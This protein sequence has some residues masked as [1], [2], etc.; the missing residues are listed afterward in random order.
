MDRRNFLARGFGLTGAF[1]LGCRDRGQEGT[2]VEI[3]G[4]EAEGAPPME[5]TLGEGRAGRRFTDL[6]AIRPGDAWLP[7]ARC[8]VRSRAPASLAGRGPWSLR[9]GGGVDRPF[10]LPLSEVA[11]LSRPRGVYCLECAGN[12]PGGRFGLLSSARWEGIAFPDLLASI[13]ARA[14]I[15]PEDALIRIRGAGEGSPEG[16]PDAGIAWTFRREDLEDAFLATAMDSA[17]LGSDHG[18]PV[19]LLVPGW[20]GCACIKWVEGIDFLGTDA[21]AT[22]H[23]RDYAGR[24]HQ[25]GEPVLARDYRPARMGLSALPIR[26]E[27]VRADGAATWRLAGLTWGGDGAGDDVQ[28]QTGDNAWKDVEVLAR[29]KDAY[30]WTH[31]THAWKPPGPGIYRVTLRPKDPGVRSPR[32]RAGYYARDCRIDY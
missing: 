16:G 31:W 10:D 24:T 32:L 27:R 23:M 25:A 8:F 13:R 20:Y 18:G 14:G 21:P 7:A 3:R 6:S 28:I 12:D 22:P 17:P 29:R 5:A 11:S 9:V 1:L 19:R 15:A 30:G 26:L 4:F 2:G